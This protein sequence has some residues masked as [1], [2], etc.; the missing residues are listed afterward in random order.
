VRLIPFRA[1]RVL[2]I[3]DDAGL[4]LSRRLLL[5]NAGYDPDSA[6]SDSVF[7]PAYVQ[8]FDAVILCQSV[9]PDSA[10]ELTEKLRQYNPGI[11]ILRVNLQAI[12]PDSGYD[13]ICDSLTDP[14]RFVEA[15]GRVLDGIPKNGA[16]VP[17]VAR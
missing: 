17:S 12:E 7:T 3:S 16:S 6:R 4:G 10:L 5:E 13:E 1:V 14:K 9:S 15:V 2:S 11:R 8:S